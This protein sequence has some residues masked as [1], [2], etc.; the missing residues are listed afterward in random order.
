MYTTTLPPFKVDFQSLS[1]S[2]SLYII[3]GDLIT[4]TASIVLL[5]ADFL[6]FFLNDDSH[7]PIKL[8]LCNFPFCP[9]IEASQ[10]Y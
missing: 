9:F 6:F 10:F 2:C 8:H 3:D 4:N 5:T 7:F 1:C